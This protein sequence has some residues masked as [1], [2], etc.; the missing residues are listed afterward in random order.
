MTDK[1]YETFITLDSSM[2][3]ESIDVDALESPR[4][5]ELQNL[6]LRGLQIKRSEDKST[7]VFN[8]DSY[9]EPKKMEESED[10]L[11]KL[12]NKLDSLSDT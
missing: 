3:E 8:D 9:E 2:N 6:P 7:I 1:H 4:E 5:Q 10:Y 11:Q 12:G